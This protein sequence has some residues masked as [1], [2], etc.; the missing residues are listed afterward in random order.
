M[1]GGKGSVE[2]PPEGKTI[3]II[4]ELIGVLDSLFIDL[5]IMFVYSKCLGKYAI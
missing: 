2:S 5:Q 4:M 3:I 1:R